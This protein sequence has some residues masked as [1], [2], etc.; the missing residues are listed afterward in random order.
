MTERVVI[1][2]LGVLAANG[3]G[4]HDFELALRK[5]QSGIRSNDAMIEHG[6]GCQVAGV[7]QGVDEIAQSYFAETSCWP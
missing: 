7:P 4:L 3:N 2:G 6:F 5:G 1:T